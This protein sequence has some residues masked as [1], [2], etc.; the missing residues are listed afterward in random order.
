M[1]AAVE[2]ELRVF[3][4]LGEGA[5]GAEV[6]FLEVGLAS[7]VVAEAG[8]VEELEPLSDRWLLHIG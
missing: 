5:E 4:A 1:A 8:A 7:E 6:P 2:L 3:L